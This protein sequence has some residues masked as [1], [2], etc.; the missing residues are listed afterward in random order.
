MFTLQRE[1]ERDIHHFFTGKSRYR[2]PRRAVLDSFPTVNNSSGV[3]AFWDSY[4]QGECIGG[5]VKRALNLEVHTQMD[6]LALHPSSPT[7]LPLASISELSRAGKM[8]PGLCSGLCRVLHRGGC[9]PKDNGQT[10]KKEGEQLRHTHHKADIYQG[11]MTKKGSWR[12]ICLTVRL[13]TIFII[14]F[15]WNQEG[16]DT[17]RRSEKDMA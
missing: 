6:A 9:D 17:D 3:L 14:F 13:E 2:C 8:P 11:L 1:W 7:T 5:M 15:G 16:Q 4:L 10:Q 12:F